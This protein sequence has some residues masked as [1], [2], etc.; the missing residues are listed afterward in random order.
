MSGIVVGTDGTAT[1]SE[2]VR[3]AARRAMYSG[4][5]LHIVSAF[6]RVPESRQRRERLDIPA[7]AEWM[8]GETGDVRAILRE[9]CE[10]AAEAADGAVV[11]THARLGNARAALREVAQRYDA[12]LIMVGNAQ[13]VYR[14]LTFRMPCRVQVV[15]T[16]ARLAVV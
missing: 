12:E 16:R 2:A 13:P 8:V 6:Q 5:V 4:D 14:R 10:V 15:D 7:D 1:A 3:E 11:L 9:A